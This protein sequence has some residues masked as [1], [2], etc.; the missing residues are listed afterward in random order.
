MRYANYSHD[1]TVR[2][3]S[4]R[5]DALWPIG[6]LHDTCSS[7]QSASSH[8]N[9]E[10]KA[11]LGI[12]LPSKGYIYDNVQNGLK[13]RPRAR[14]GDFSF[15]A[16]WQRVRQKREVRYAFS[17]IKPDPFPIQ[18]FCV[19]HSQNHYMIYMS[20]FLAVMMGP[21]SE[22][23]R[24]DSRTAVALQNIIQHLT[25]LLPGLSQP[26][27]DRD[28]LLLRIRIAMPGNCKWP[29]ID[30]H[31]TRPDAARLRSRLPAN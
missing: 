6:K 14:I 25:V 7:A 15:S 2:A 9:P 4:S 1:Q 8:W 17:Y 19:V 11:P 18:C 13:C 22:V 10:K 29:H 16:I 5:I 12:F 31:I 3:G 24:G 27:C 30:F 28:D 21:P 20:Q 23:A 26:T